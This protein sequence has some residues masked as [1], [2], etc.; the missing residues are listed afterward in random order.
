M[1][2]FLKFKAYLRLREAV[3]KADVAHSKDGDR[4]YVVPSTDGTLIVMDRKNFKI[5]RRKGYI[6]RNVYVKDLVRESFYFTP[7][8]GGNG[9]ITKEFRR[10]KMKEYYSWCEAMR[11]L[12][13]ANKK[14]GKKKNGKDK[15]D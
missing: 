9:Y 4:Y 1:N 6:N 5:L 11:K 3:I 13:K 15:K 8:Q 14:K 12:K 2:I 7:Y 10:M